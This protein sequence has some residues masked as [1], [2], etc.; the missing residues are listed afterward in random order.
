MEH[1]ELL[2]PIE[3]LEIMGSGSI[4]VPPPTLVT[5]LDC[6]RLVIYRWNFH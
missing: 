4:C 6:L 2:K 5:D 1:F 3:P